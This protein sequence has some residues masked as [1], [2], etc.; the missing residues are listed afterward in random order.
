LRDWLRLSRFDVLTR[1]KGKH[2]LL[3]CILS[4]IIVALEVE[5]TFLRNRNGRSLFKIVICLGNYCCQQE[6]LSPVPQCLDPL[7]GVLMR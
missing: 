6:M 2:F 5:F 7:V 3:V 4:I 1:K